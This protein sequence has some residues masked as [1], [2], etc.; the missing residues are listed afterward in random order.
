MNFIIDRMWKAAQAHPDRP[1]IV[2]GNRSWTYGEVWDSARRLAGVIDRESRQ[3]IVGFFCDRDESA[4][5]AIVGIV[6]AGRC[7][8]PLNPKLND[9]R[10]RQIA[11]MA[12]LDVVVVGKGKEEAA[13]KLF[14]D[15]DVRLVHIGGGDAVAAGRGPGVS[16][17]EIAASPA[18]EPRRP[19]DSSALA[20]L[21]FTSGSTGVPKGV[22]I[23]NGNLC[24]YV[25][26]MTAYYGYGPN[27]L[28]A[29]TCELTFDISVH[30]MFCAF[31]NGGAIVRIAGVELL[32]PARVVRK[33]GITCWFSVP[34]L[35]SVMSK[36]HGLEP[37]TMPSLRVVVFCGEALPVSLALAWSLAAPNAL[38][39]NLY[40]PTEATVAM[41]RHRLDPE[42]SPTVARAGLVALGKPYPD[43]NVL[44][45]DDDMTPLTA[46]CR[47]MLLL[48]GTQ[49]SGSYWKE[50]RQT[51]EK[52]IRLAGDPDTLWYVSGDLVE[53]DEDGCLFF[54]GRADNQIKFRG[55]RIE[56][57]E[58]E[59][60]LRRVL[61]T[62]LVVALPWPK[63]GHEVDGITAVAAGTPKPVEPILKMLRE[64]LPYYMVP[65]HV[66]FMK[67]LPR[68]MSGKIDRNAI[69]AL[70]D[71]GV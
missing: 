27:D 52:Y 8:V 67:E 68:N 50:P 37:N 29:Q 47:G 49:L 22:P 31:A 26:H 30:D 59:D 69:L 55:H 21:L 13:A 32:A 38:I 42:T 36:A 53:M 46:P 43:Q 7:Y 11:E 14:A 61:G 62:D 16:R 57:N 5:Q 34:S 58:I 41:A 48:S 39:E 9:E 51:A 56:L 28:H 17:A 6:A 19:A 3:P 65:H 23:S 66:S 35:G 33:H 45:V 64:H 15:L 2:I 4:Y 24:A 1:M 70:L 40:G 71:S 18:I 20:Y 10:L 54:V 60:A 25:D 12:D 63:K 44:V